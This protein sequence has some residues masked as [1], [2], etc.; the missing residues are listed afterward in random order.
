MKQSCTLAVAALEELFCDHFEGNKV[1]RQGVPFDLSHY[2]L[3]RNRKTLRTLESGHFNLLPPDQCSSSTTTNGK[4]TR[5]PFLKHLRSNHYAEALPLP[6]PAAATTH[7][8]NQI[9]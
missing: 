9:P 8:E 7:F 5:T 2:S 3:L 4:Y 6:I 1:P